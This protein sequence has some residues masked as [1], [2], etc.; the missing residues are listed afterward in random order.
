MAGRKGN[1]AEGK[2]L[3]ITLSEQSI[4]ALHK[5][6]MRGIYGRNPNEVAARFVDQALQGLVQFPAITLNPEDFKR[7]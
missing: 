5:I 6:A 4:D 3:T 2:P 1:A 7:E